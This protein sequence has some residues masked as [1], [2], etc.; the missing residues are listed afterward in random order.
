MFTKTFGISSL[1]YMQREL[2]GKIE[3]D[4]VKLHE[5]LLGYSRHKAIS[6]LR[7]HTE[8]LEPPMKQSDTFHLGCLVGC[9]L[10]LLL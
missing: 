4:Y 2:G 5:N 8:T 1:G 3:H 10:P 7:R 9:M 6:R